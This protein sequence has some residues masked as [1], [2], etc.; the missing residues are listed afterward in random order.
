MPR[1][2]RNGDQGPKG[3][4][5]TLPRSHMNKTDGP[6]TAVRGDLYVCAIH[7]KGNPHKLKNGCSCFKVETADRGLQ[8]VAMQYATKATCGCRI[9]IASSVHSCCPHLDAKAKRLA[10]REDVIRSAK[11]SAAEGLKDGTMGKEEAKDLT[12]AADELERL[13]VDVRRAE[14]SLASYRSADLPDQFI[15]DGKGDT[16]AGLRRMTHQ[17]NIGELPEVLRDRTLWENRDIGYNAEVYYDEL[18]G[19]HLFTFRGTDDAKDVKPDVLQAM[20]YQTEQYDAGMRVGQT[21]AD[22]MDR[23]RGGANYFGDRSDV[24][25]TGHSLGGGLA[26]AA[27]TVAQLPYTTFNAAGLHSAT[28]PR[29][30]DGRLGNANGASLGTR[31]TLSSDGLTAAQTSPRTVYGVGS[32]LLPFVGTYLTIKNQGRMAEGLGNTH[33]ELP[34]V[35]RSTRIG[36]EADEYDSISNPAAG[37]SQKNMVESIEKKKKDKQTQ[38]GLMMQIR[39]W[40]QVGMAHPWSEGGKYKPPPTR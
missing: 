16:A 22:Y 14:A 7:S 24:R 19:E 39:G 8:P 12:A 35:K 13:N 38:M 40:R 11:E 3:V 27:G 21:L 34:A 26:S 15:E 33:Y 20:G 10:E 31:Y 4:I 23:N 6:D 2:A 37:H 25:F 32:V 9:E 18:N 30:T 17:N 29:L 28:V 36:A 5:K 1:V